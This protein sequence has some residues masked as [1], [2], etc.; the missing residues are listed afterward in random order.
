MVKDNNDFP[1]VLEVLQ[2]GWLR[3]FCNNRIRILKLSSYLEGEDVIQ[4][5]VQCL[6]NELQ[7][8]KK[9]EHP[10]AWAK[11]VSERHIQ[12]HFKKNCLTEATPSDRLE[13]LAGSQSE[14]MNLHFFDNY[15]QLHHSMG[16]LKS[17]SRQIIE[18]RFF[19]KLDWKKI[20][21]VLSS[22]ENTEISA[23]TARKRGER[24]IIELR[25]Y[26]RAS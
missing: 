23:A 17:T 14:E 4:Y 18:M 16:Q 2:S 9:I 24:A 7:S 5:A 11:T 8:G 26:Y 20:A 13:Y 1:E 15:E 12:K 22:Q 10:I 21:L 25:S 6:A 19:Q 3:T